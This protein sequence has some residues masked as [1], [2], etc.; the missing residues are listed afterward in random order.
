MARSYKDLINSG[1]TLTKYERER[2]EREIWSNSKEI[3]TKQFDYLCGV[4]ASRGDFYTR[5]KRQ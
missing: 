4:A 5:Y 1:K 3:S 2:V